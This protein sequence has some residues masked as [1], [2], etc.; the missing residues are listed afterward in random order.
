MLSQIGKSPSYKRLN[1]IPLCMYVCVSHI[2]CIH[3]F[4]V[5]YL[6]SFHILVFTNNSEHGSTDIS[7]R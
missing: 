6:D 4:T 7:L 1:I 5:R 2:F 3:L